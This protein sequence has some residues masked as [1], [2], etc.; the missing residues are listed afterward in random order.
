MNLHDVKGKKTGGK[1]KGV[2]A[3]ALHF[4]LGVFDL[5]SGM[6]PSLLLV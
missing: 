1:V 2:L 6:R 4:R 5:E 3:F